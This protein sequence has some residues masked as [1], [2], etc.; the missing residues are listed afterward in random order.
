MQ[1]PLWG[2]VKTEWTHESLGFFLDEDLVASCLVLYRALPVPSRI[3]YFGQVTLAYVSGGPVVNEDA[4]AFAVIESLVEYLKKRHVFQL[5]LGM[6]GDVET[7]DNATVRAAMKSGVAEHLMDVE[8]E[9]S[10]KMLALQ[11]RLLRIGFKQPQVQEGF[12]IGQPVFQARI[13]LSKT[14]DE[15]LKRMNQTSRSETR[16]SMKTGLSIH[17]G[18]QWIPQ[19]HELYVQTAK[20]EDFTPRPMSYFTHM[21]KTLNASEIAD[22]EVLVATY[23]N[24]P[25]AGAIAIRQ[26]EFAWYPYGGSSIE[27][28]N[29]HAPR[30]LQLAQITDAVN[31][32]CTWYDLGGVSGSLKKSGPTSGL[33]QF[34]TAMGSD[35][36]KTHGEWVLPLNK[37]LS[38]LF[39]A[40]MESRSRR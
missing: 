28:R 11:S 8:H 7:W 3:P 24:T 18:S 9:I 40:Y 16:K 2:D 6:A 32:G 22:V 26:G 36:I 15:T 21:V 30:A 27:H 20:R 34:K 5:R 38:T 12:G 35:I 37:P 1:N 10:Y 19:F 23:E 25:L 39:D 14:V 17:R 29:L 33:M 4:D 31:S 13:P